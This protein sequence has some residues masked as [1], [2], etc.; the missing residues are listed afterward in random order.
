MN[1]CQL[2]ARKVL[3]ILTEFC[4]IQYKIGNVKHITIYIIKKKKFGR[5]IAERGFSN[6]VIILIEAAVDFN[7]SEQLISPNL[8]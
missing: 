1:E 3:D 4:A 8:D 2:C 5:V 6:Y 7:A